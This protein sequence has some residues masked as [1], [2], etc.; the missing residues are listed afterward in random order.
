MYICLYKYIHI[1][2][3]IYIY[4]YTCMYIVYICIFICTHIYRD[5]YRYMYIYMFPYLHATHMFFTLIRVYI[6]VPIFRLSLCTGS[7]KC[8][9]IRSAACT[10]PIGSTI[11]TQI[12]IWRRRDAATTAQSSPSTSRSTACACSAPKA[13]VRLVLALSSA[14]SSRLTGSSFVLAR[15]CIPVCE[16]VFLCWSVLQC[17]NM[18]CSVLKCVVMCYSS[19]SQCDALYVLYAAVCYRVLLQCVATCCTHGSLLYSSRVAAHCV[20]C[21]TM[22]SVAV[23][24]SHLQ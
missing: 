9:A 5:I 6:Y 3:Y 23:C 10:C 20:C 7:F 16:C 21:C 11:L 22:E 14:L 12:L 24:C 17:V 1:Y 2:I 19:L 4:I 8:L 13:C 18:C 15:L